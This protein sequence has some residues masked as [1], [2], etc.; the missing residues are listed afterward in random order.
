[1][2]EPKDP[3]KKPK[4]EWQ[5]KGDAW[6]EN[7]DISVDDVDK[8]IRI[9]FAALVIVIILIILEAAGIYKL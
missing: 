2:E 5:Y 3:G 9:A 8:V 7:L 6:Y 1:M 4:K